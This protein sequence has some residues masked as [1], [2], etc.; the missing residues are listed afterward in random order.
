MLKSISQ[1]GKGIADLWLTTFDVAD[2]EEGT[3]DFNPNS[4][5]NR[6]L[7]NQLNILSEN[8]SNIAQSYFF[9]AE[10]T[11]DNKTKVMA[12]PEALHTGYELGVYYKQ[13]DAWIKA[14]KRLKENKISVNTG[15]YNDI[16]GTWITILKPV[17]NKNGE[18][19]AIFGIDLDASLIAVGKKEL[20]FWLT[21]LLAIFISIMIPLL[22][23]GLKRLLFPTKALLEG[24]AQVSQGN[25]NVYIREDGTEFG[26]INRNFNKMVSDLRLLFYKVKSTS[27]K[28]GRQKNERNDISLSNAIQNINKIE[29][30]N[31]ARDEAIKIEKMNAVSQLAASVA[32]EVRNPLTVVKGFLQLFNEETWLPAT[33]REKVEL[34]ISEIDRAH[35]IIN[36]YLSLAKPGSKHFDTVDVSATLKTSIELINSYAKTFERNI[37]FQ[38]QIEDH[39]FSKANKAELIQ[40]CINLLKNSIEAM[41]EIGGTLTINARGDDDNIHIEIIDTGVGMN[42]D[43]LQ[44]LGSPYYSTKD[45]GTGI[46][47][48]VSYQ[49]VERLSG[50]IKINSIEG[51]GTYIYLSIPRHFND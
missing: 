17:I 10:I 41:S 44:R 22:Y 19:I 42:K 34:M 3:K 25:F 35:Q 16:L 48:M 33:E 6:K 7:I 39:L 36:D 11:D 20:I 1:Q 5:V 15:V 46:G 29:M 27:E 28:M 8:N 14:A 49:I 18:I 24:I 9:G 23:I 2:I 21:S 51:E 4:T 47:L 45:R 30:F 37:L 50:Q 32:H 38:I 26:A 43:Q 12:Y 13:P 31:N 40:L